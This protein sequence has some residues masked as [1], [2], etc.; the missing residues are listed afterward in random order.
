MNNRWLPVA[1]IGVVL[2]YFISKF[3]IA[4]SEQ[5][6]FLDI[7]AAVVGVA[8]LFASAMVY[9]QLSALRYQAETKFET[10][11]ESVPDGIAVVNF[12]GLIVTINKQ[13]EVLFGYPRVELVHQPI[14]ILVPVSLQSCP[15][16]HR[17]LM[18]RRKDGTKFP[19]EVSLSS[20]QTEQ[21]MFVIAIV[22]DQTQRRQ[23]EEEHYKLQTAEQA[24]VLRDTFISIASHELKTPLTSLLLQVETVLLRTQRAPV[25]S[26][27]NMRLC[28]VREDV[29]RL[30][31]LIDTML[32]VSK[33]STDGL[34]LQLEPVDLSALVTD[35]VGRFSME[36][37]RVRVS[38]Q[39]ARTL[40]PI[41]GLWDQNRLDQVVVNL[42]S[43]ALKYGAGWPVTVDLC[44]REERGR[45]CAILTVADQGIGIAAED[46]QRIFQR[47]ERAV[48]DQRYGGFG[49]GLWIVHTV[50]EA[51]GGQVQVESQLGTGS[52]FTVTLPIE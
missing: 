46:Q 16:T 48:S 11:L 32:D 22:R 34:E 26:D 28:S 5:F 33:L 23:A 15:I 41:V 52:V 2:I 24:I 20:V 1:A 36:A 39:M 19:V 47:F 31:H 12:A 29:E 51:H 35:I 40:A 50:V 45:M 10:L 37:E 49:L 42:L 9:R 21:Q 17:A 38:L 27:L 7:F 18:G 30:K 25:L 3:W 43:N 13:I 6:L 8:A 4:D 44:E 14:E